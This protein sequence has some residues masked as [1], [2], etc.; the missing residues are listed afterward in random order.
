MS[1][2]E[3]PFVPT[4]AVAAARALKWANVGAGDVLY[5]LG[6]GDGTVAVAAVHRG[7]DSVVCVEQRPALAAKAEAALRAAQANVSTPG[8]APPRVQVVVGDLF[9]VDISAAT[10][11]FCFLLP[12]TLALLRKTHLHRLRPGTRMVSREFE[13]FGW[14]C[15]D[16]FRVALPDGT[17]DALFLRWETPVANED[18]LVADEGAA[19]VQEAAIEHL[20]ECAAEE[21]AADPAAPSG[22]SRERAGRMHMRGSGHAHRRSRAHEVEQ[23]EVR[24]ELRRER[25]RRAL[26]ARVQ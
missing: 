23:P 8:H 16:R 3:V 4:S 24:V 7:V 6:C 12:E 19:G 14:P 13:V 15:G 1:L 5:E 9:Q 10:V 11:V 2:P 26:R 18:S 17:A 20:L 25:R 22:N 21:A